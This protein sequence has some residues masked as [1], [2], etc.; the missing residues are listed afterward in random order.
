MHEQSS[1][2]QHWI[3]VASILKCYAD[4]KN[5]DSIY[6]AGQTRLGD[7]YGP[8][9]FN[10]S[11][12]IFSGAIMRVSVVLEFNFI[13]LLLNHWLVSDKKLIREENVWSSEGPK[14]QYS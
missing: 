9:W 4:D 3:L 10:I 8:I 2:T 6:R 11:G 7:Q 12:V 1:P 14:E 5:L 13:K